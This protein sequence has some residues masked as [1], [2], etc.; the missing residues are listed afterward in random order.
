MSGVKA[1]LS[2]SQKNY[3]CVKCEFVIE[4]IKEIPRGIVYHTAPKMNRMV[5]RGSVDPSNKKEVCSERYMKIFLLHLV[6]VQSYWR[7]TALTS[8]CTQ[9]L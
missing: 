1:R 9:S 2:C 3:E 5:L 7:A 4:M 6:V 8:K